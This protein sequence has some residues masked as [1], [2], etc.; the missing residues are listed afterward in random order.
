MTDRPLAPTYEP[1]PA[2]RVVYRWF[3]DNIQ[4]DESWV[5]DVRELSA[6]G[7]VR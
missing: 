7:S 3:F 2:L 4:V 6:R 5:R 1:N